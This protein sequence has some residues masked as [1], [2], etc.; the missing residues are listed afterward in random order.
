MAVFEAAGEGGLIEPESA[1]EL[2]HAVTLWHN[3]HGILSLTVEEGFVEATAPPALLG[4]IERACDVSH[5]DSLKEEMR[6]TAAR[7]A[8][9]FD[10][11]LGGS[12]G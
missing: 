6:E 7:T 9:H 12:E 5:F 11:L 10:R 1:R 2:T 3:L 4:A 8:Q